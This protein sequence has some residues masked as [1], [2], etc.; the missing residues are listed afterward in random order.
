MTSKRHT[1]ANESKLTRVERAYQSLLDDVLQA[2]F[3]G[4]A[5]LELT[6]AN[7]TIQTIARAVERIDKET[8]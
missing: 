8:V 1:P 6:I 3:H 7:G 5:R 4:V 2:G